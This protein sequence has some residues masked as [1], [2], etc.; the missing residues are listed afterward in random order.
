MTQIL[1]FEHLI[2]NIIDLLCEKLDT[3]FVKTGAPCDMAD[4]VLYGKLNHGSI[5]MYG[6]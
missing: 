5:G 3:R 6:D 4:Y 2:D 1:E